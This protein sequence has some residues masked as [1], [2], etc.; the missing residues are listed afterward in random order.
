MGYRCVSLCS[1]KELSSGSEE[2]LRAGALSPGREGGG[3]RGKAQGF[4]PD[5]GWGDR[6]FLV[7]VIQV[8]GLQRA[9]GLPHRVNGKII[10]IKLLFFLD[11]VHCHLNASR[12]PPA[13]PPNC[14]SLRIVPT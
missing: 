11:F 10:I 8:V 3:E 5:R 4:P 13:P 2:A 7:G 9:K 1:F 12:V 6:C 14:F